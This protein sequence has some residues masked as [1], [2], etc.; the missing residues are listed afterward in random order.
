MHAAAAGFEYFD[1]FLA[2]SCRRLTTLSLVIESGG[3]SSSSAHVVPLML[4]YAET[5]VISSSLSLVL[6]LA[7]STLC[8][9]GA[10]VAIIAASFRAAALCY[11]AAGCAS[12]FDCSAVRPCSPMPR[13]RPSVRPSVCRICQQLAAGRRG[14]HGVA[15]FIGATP[16]APGPHPFSALLPVLMAAYLIVLYRHSGGSSS[17]RRPSQRES[18]GTVSYFRSLC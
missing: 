1:I 6:A 18:G 3:G 16:A 9:R 2:Q 13:I 17:N 15:R 4:L 8:I 10:K 7:L 11:S 5:V 14:C 12:V